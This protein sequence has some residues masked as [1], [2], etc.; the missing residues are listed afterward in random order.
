MIEISDSDEDMSPPPKRSAT[1]AKKGASV[2]ASGSA[3]KR[4]TPVKDDDDSDSDF[5]V[6]APAESSSKKQAVSSSSGKPAAKKAAS[7]KKTNKATKSD[8]PAGANLGPAGLDVDAAI[9]RFVDPELMAKKNAGKKLGFVPKP[10]RESGGGGGGS[11]E[12]PQGEPNCLAACSM[13]FTGELSI[14]SREEA[15]TLAKRYGAKVV[16]A[17]TSKTTHVIMGQGAGASKLAKIKSSGLKC[18][19]LD[20]EGFF[21]LIRS[22]KANQLDP[23]TAQK[24]ADEEKKMRVAAK[25]LEQQ[26]STQSKASSSTAKGKKARAE[27]EDYDSKGTGKG[28]KLGAAI[29]GAGK[30]GIG[31]SDPASSLWTTKYAP[32]KLKDLVGNPGAV[33][34]LTNWLEAWPKS[35]ACNFKKPGPDASGGYKAV[36]LAGPPGI[37][38]T[39][40]AHLVARSLGYSP[41]ELNASDVR[42]KKLIELALKDSLNNTNLDG[43]FHRGRVA[44]S[45]GADSINITNKTVLIM[46]EVD[47]MGG[48]DRGGVGAINALIKKTKVPII[49]ICNDAGN[50]KMKPFDATTFKIKFQKPT[51]ASVKTRMMAVCYA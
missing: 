3:G 14:L 16:T 45:A 29:S 23:K 27:P 19:I 4:K 36:L 8:P 38:K 11:T 35:L 48:G 26:F 32:R 39:S 13:V 24:M 7:P 6:T 9:E 20:E 15:Q 43:W 5:E 41:I 22:S 18:K 30:A 17:P 25:E 21:D 12:V 34:K 28:L 2:S 42:S 33:K 31:D 40:T 50:Q 51:D 37:G 44:P 1:P 46:D 49:C 47:G 10:T